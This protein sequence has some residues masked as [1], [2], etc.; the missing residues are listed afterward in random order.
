MLVSFTIFHKGG[1]ILYQHMDDDSKEAD[2]SLSHSINTW[3]AEIYFNPT[4]SKTVHKNQILIDGNTRKVVEW[5]ETSELIALAVYPD[6]RHED[7]PWIR[8]LLM[9]S[10][11]EYQV[12]A[13][14]RSASTAA[15]ASS[16]GK[17]NDI[18]DSASTE[19]QALFGKTFEILFQKHRNESKSSGNTT[20]VPT[21]YAKSSKTYTNT[22]NN[23]GGKE[24][25]QWHDGK[26]KVTEKAMKE[27]DKSKAATKEEIVNSEE[28][29][30]AEARAAYLPTDADLEDFDIEDTTQ[31]VD[32]E[33][34]DDGEG[35]GWGKS[36]QGLFAQM[37]GQKVLTKQ[38]LE[39]P[40]KE[41]NRL[42][43]SKNVAGDIADQICRKVQE[44]L[45]GKKLNSMYR[46]KTAVRQ[47]LEQ[48]I[49]EL[50][51]PS[52]ELSLLRQVV[53][54]RDQASSFFARS[55]TQ[56]PFVI[57]VVGINGVGKSTSLA[58][59]AYYLKTNGCCPLL[60]AC[61]TFRSGAVEQLSVHAKCLGLP[62]YSKGYSKDPSSVAKAAIEQAT[63]DGNDVVL[64]DTAGRMQ[65]N[66]PLMKALGKLAAENQP[67]MVIF[68][69]E[70]L[71]GNDG[72]DQVQMFDK[73]ISFQNQHQKVNAILLTKFDT[74]SDKV[75]AALTMT[76]VT[77][78]PILFV[79]T[80]QKYHHLQKLSTAAV[81]R[82]LFH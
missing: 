9:A 47:A 21:S 66:L 18:V 50:L 32:D 72:V 11:Q 76:H 43:T 39:G 27:L 41:I 23:K 63:Q 67:D 31:L 4:I 53:S 45:V 78:A 46:V 61:D 58:K 40:L 13:Q 38:D 68:V 19:N 49:N 1:L 2:Y 34:D 75:G 56:R 22:S 52:T 57:A 36:L 81:I 73:A 79:G 29:A 59:L 35:G 17:E 6:L 60:A 62:I 70:A 80:G 33:N 77:N 28:Q 30:L 15:T 71:V 10:L 12:F 14:A 48:V 55:K 24:K 44:S 42:L 37:T 25:R 51:L 3:L 65:N 20:I 82:S 74:V 26:G 16:A 54:K 64:V 5:E 7:F 8:S 69:G